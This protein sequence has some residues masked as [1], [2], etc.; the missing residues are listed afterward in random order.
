M[1][2]LVASDWMKIKEAPHWLTQ[3]FRHDDINARGPTFYAR[4]TFIQFLAAM[5]S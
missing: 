4:E 3:F 5:S 2:N 1:K